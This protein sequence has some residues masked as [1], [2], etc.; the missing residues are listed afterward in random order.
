MNPVRVIEHKRDGL[1]HTQEEIRF[2]VDSATGI[3]HGMKP[4][5]LAAWLM[6]VVWRG[7]DIEE[8][9][10]LTDAMAHSGAILDLTGLPKPWVDKHSTGGVGDKTTIA[11]LP[12]LAACGLTIVKM[13]GRGLG[14]TGGTIDKLASVPGF[15]TSLTPEQLKTQ[16][17]EI[18]LALTGQ[19]YS[20]TPADGT[21]YALRDVT[22]TVPSIPLIC[23]SVLSKKIAG[24]AEVISIDLKCGS[25]A[26]METP[27]DAR[28]LASR[29]KG[30]G[31]MLGVKV[32]VEI[33]DMDQPLGR[34]AGNLLEVI[35]AVDTVY[36][37]GDSRFTELCIILCGSM[38]FESGLSSSSE[39]GQLR[40]KQ[41]LADGSA[42]RKM[43]QW[44]LAQGASVQP[45]ELRNLVENLAVAEV[46]A[47]ESGWIKRLDAGMVGEAAVEVGAG[48]R[49][50]EDNI[51]PQ[52]GIETCVRVG[53]E[54]KAGDVL[55]RIFA[56]NHEIAAAT[57]DMLEPACE[58]SPILVPERPL[59]M[60][61]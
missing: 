51:D 49:S 22:G 4:E 36:G 55:L 48:R 2:I 24:G 29:M 10:W 60:Q 45:L 12:M 18:G 20:L 17:R 30:V 35:E 42:Q 58:I 26:F 40:A 44:F 19:S 59:V 14:K 41:C 1:K 33:T 21:L 39:E 61:S 46:K 27:E 7:L 43:E 6:A 53:Q 5:Q 34:Y 11:L 50:K 57:K 15:Q 32:G 56:R 23:A 8:T 25:G 16:A 9:A 52:V 28:A 3:N 54:V 13:S 38:L 31:E 37:K 47:K